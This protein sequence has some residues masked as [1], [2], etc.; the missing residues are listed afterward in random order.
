MY[1]TVLLIYLGF[2]TPVLLFA[3]GS[4]DEQHEKL[5]CDYAARPSMSSERYK[6]ASIQYNFNLPESN[7]DDLVRAQLDTNVARQVSL[8]IVYDSEG[9]VLGIPR[10]HR[11]VVEIQ[12]LSEPMVYP[13]GG[14]VNRVS[15]IGSNVPFDDVSVRVFQET[16]APLGKWSIDESNLDIDGTILKY[17]TSQQQ[18]FSASDF[19]TYMR[20]QRG[21]QE[22]IK[23]DMVVADLSQ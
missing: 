17:G 22:Q 3:N 23:F 19:V 15:A 18:L 12:Y 8:C 5:L 2:L 14:F 4:V 11:D 20:Q 9:S 21:P 13:G 1:K 6:P 7:L 16:R 10:Y